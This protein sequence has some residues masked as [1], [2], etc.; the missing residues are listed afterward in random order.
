MSVEE[1]VTRGIAATR[2]LAKR[3]L[4]WLRKWPDLAWITTDRE[5]NVVD[6]GLSDVKEMSFVQNPCDLVLNSLT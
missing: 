3:Q 6:S 1:A 2:Q 4:T 5:G